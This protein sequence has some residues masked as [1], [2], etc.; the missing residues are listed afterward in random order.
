MRINQ[1]NYMNKNG[2]H[3]FILQKKT[4]TMLLA[5]VIKV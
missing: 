2:K 1:G 5:A 4:A 3:V